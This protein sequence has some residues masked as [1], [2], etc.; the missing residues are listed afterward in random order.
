MQACES[1]SRWRQR[2]CVLHDRPW[3][4]ILVA[5]GGDLLMN[6]FLLFL[7][8]GLSLK[9][10][11]RVGAHGR[12]TRA[13]P[14]T[15]GG[16][17]HPLRRHRGARGRGALMKLETELTKPCGKRNVLAQWVRRQQD[18]HDLRNILTSAQLVTDR[19]RNVRGSDGQT[20][21]LQLLAPIHRRVASMRILGIRAR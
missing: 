6:C 9:R 7:R 3:H 15:R 13:R 4:R 14:K 16:S 10:S 2:L 20:Y 18:Q 8:C 12:I 17:L 21:G 11:R 1:K 5:V 19:H